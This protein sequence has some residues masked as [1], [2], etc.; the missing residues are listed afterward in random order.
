MKCSACGTELENGRCPFCGYRPTQEDMMAEAAWRRQKAEIG[1]GPAGEDWKAERP[2]F[3]KPGRAAPKAPAAGNRKAPR[4]RAAAPGHP[5]PAQP[6]AKQSASRPE[7]KRKRPD[8]RGKGMLLVKLMIALW[9]L[10]CVW[11][12]LQVLAGETGIDLIGIL[13]GTG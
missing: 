10:F 11:S 4:G 2:A 13:S 12:F 1:S 9:I 8:R 5:K 6:R 7:R 3:P